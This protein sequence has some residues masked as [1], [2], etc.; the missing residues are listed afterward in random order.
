MNNSEKKI[1]FL[2]LE[3]VVSCGGA[4]VVKAA[5]DIEAGFFQM[6]KD[7]V[8]QPFKTTL[9]AKNADHEHRTF[10]PLMLT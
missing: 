8:L 5:K 9:K 1:L 7:K 6:V 2:N 10:Y 3:D 4:D